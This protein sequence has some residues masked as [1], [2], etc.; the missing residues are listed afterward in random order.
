M[1]T[2]HLYKHITWIDVCEP[3]QEEVR[4]LIETYSIDPS[5]SN[6]M[7]LPSPKSQVYDYKDLLYLV[8]YFP[9][10]GKNRKITNTKEVDFL[11]NSKVIVTIHY[12]PIEALEHFSKYFEVS[13]ILKNQHIP[14]AGYIFFEIIKS[15]YANVRD[16]VATV[17]D[18]LKNIEPK[19]FHGR[20]KEVVSTLSVLN[21]TL[22]QFKQMISTQRELLELTTTYAGQMF[23]DDF[24]KLSTAILSEHTK[25]MKEIEYHKETLKELWNINDTLL[26][27]KQN[28]I[29]KNLTMISFITFPLSLIVALFHLH[30]NLRL[31]DS[32]S[33]DFWILITVLSTAILCMIF[34]FKRR[35]WV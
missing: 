29:M 15:L 34:F 5:V 24:K 28:E 30:A 20:E 17:E 1:I 31:A 25:T 10:R 27:T 6:N 7:L 35:R 33:G 23:G 19:I 26:S 3:T 32:G 2:K 16:E 18:E 22:L 9:T 4:E 14:H 12:E 21:R 13:T 8:L 11:V